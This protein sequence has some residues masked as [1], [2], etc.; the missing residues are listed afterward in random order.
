M[1]IV[2]RAMMS[3][4]AY[5]AAAEVY[6]RGEAEFNRMIRRVLADRLPEISAGSA[7]A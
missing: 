1:A 4:G 2:Y 7:L 6:Q 5:E 3:Y